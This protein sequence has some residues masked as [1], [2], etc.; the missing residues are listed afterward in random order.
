MS[1]AW[2]TEVSKTLHD[3]ALHIRITFVLIITDTLPEYC[4]SGTTKTE[5]IIVLSWRNGIL[6]SASIYPLY[7]KVEPPATHKSNWNMSKLKSPVLCSNYHKIWDI[8]V[9]IEL[10]STN[11]WHFMPQ[12]STSD[13]FLLPS[14]LS[15]RGVSV[16]TQLLLLSDLTW[17]SLQ[18]KT[19]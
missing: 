10:V 5:T 14:N 1:H 13:S 9:T 6:T 16:C 12:I 18:F 11:T 15:I 8:A 19:S 4:I 2:G 7:G 17:S 3:N